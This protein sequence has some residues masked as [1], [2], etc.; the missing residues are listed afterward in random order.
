MLHS[1]LPAFIG[2]HFS[3]TLAE[4]QALSEQ[5]GGSLCWQLPVSFLVS[6][7]ALALSPLSVYSLGSPDTSRAV[8]TP[9]RVQQSQTC[10]HISLC[11]ERN[12]ADAACR[13]LP[14]DGDLG[15]HAE[16]DLC[17]HHL[18]HSS[19]HFSATN[20]GEHC[21]PLT[22]PDRTGQADGIKLRNKLQSSS[23]LENCR[24]VVSLNS[25]LSFSAFP[26]R[27]LDFRCRKE[28]ME[29]GYSQI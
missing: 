3:A 24:A 15:A 2:Q 22:V 6:P 28:N 14:W 25:L 5:A 11:R 19:G 18:T 23:L 21:Q 26:V 29:S 4:R 27:N 13:E 10:H 8:E 9:A 12:R 17:W 1:S 16:S 7:G 20:S